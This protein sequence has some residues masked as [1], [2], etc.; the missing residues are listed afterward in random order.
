MEGEGQ[1]QGRGGERVALRAR[2]NSP[3][4]IKTSGR[5]CGCPPARLHRDKARRRVSETGRQEP[6]GSAR[7]S[8][9]L[10]VRGSEPMRPAG[11]ATLAVRRGASGRKGC[12]ASMI[13]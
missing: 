6:R 11:A 1:G 3:S 10:G 12:L 13:Q 5:W 2:L 7:R 4:L 8:G 9:A